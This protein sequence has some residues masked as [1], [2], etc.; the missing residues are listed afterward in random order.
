M[1]RIGQRQERRT[2]HSPSKDPITGP[3]RHAHFR[4][5]TEAHLVEKDTSEPTEHRSLQEA[6]KRQMRTQEKRKFAGK[7]TMP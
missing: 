6:N 1:S 2:S 3:A 7:L 4:Q 5:R